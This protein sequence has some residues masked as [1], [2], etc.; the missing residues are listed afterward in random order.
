M[1]ES[2]KIVLTNKVYYKT[3]GIDVFRILCVKYSRYSK[4]NKKYEA[5]DIL[6]LYLKNREISN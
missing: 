2:Y 5:S 1:P 3:L 6:R 4:K